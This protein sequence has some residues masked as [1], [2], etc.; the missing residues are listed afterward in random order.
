MMR[1]KESS[2]LLS[3]YPGSLQDLPLVS[4]VAIRLAAIAHERSLTDEELVRA[5][6]SDIFLCAKAVSVANS[7]F[8]NLTHTACFTIEEALA[9]IGFDFAT[10]LLKNATQVV[11]PLAKESAEK[12]WAHCMATA[13]I[14]KALCPHAE[15][16][17][18]SSAAVYWAAMIHDIGF[19]IEAN[20]EPLHFS[21]VLQSFHER[22]NADDQHCVLGHGLAHYW[23]LP[24]WVKELLRR[25]HEVS[26]HEADDLAPLIGLLHVAHAIA[27]SKEEE[28]EPHHLSNAGLPASCIAQ[29]IEQRDRVFERLKSVQKD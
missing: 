5:F 12:L 23:S 2:F 7:I 16:V 19:L 26:G 25:H 8:F 3:Y 21:D 24:S 18:Q 6:E 17:T 20:F 4:P 14:A 22:E 28:I 13:C 29:V 1:S 10:A 15:K 9:R 27:Q 11:E